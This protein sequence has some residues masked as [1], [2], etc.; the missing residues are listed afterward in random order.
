MRA[1]N[2]LFARLRNFI[3]NRRID[4]R[5]QEEIEQH[6]NFQANENIRAGM[7]PEEARRQAVLKFGSVQTVREDCH[8]EEGLP[9]VEGV[10]Q[11]LHYALRVLRKSPAFTLVAVVT[12]ALGIGAN[13]TVFSVVD[14]VLL[15]PLPYMHPE[16][17]VEAE[18]FF[19]RNSSPSNLSYPDFFDWRAQNHSFEHLVSYHDNSYTLTGVGRAVYVGAQVVSWDLLP[20]LGLHPAIGRGFTPDEEKRGTRVVL[21]SYALWQSQFGADKTVLGQT[22]QLSGETFTVIGVMP[23]NFRFPITAPKTDLWTTLAVD[24]TPTG[25]GITNRGM[26]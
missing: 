25:D 14:A 22:I 21:L 26:H 19:D 16:R 20:M 11:D 17:L 3:T 7:A 18:S 23:A 1:L 5:L 12:L 15:R 6:L 4:R 9:L 24:D 8:S 13:T 10:L 2:R